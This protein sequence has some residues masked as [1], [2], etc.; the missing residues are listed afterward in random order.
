[1]THYA[2]HS[3]SI[4]DDADS[5]AS[6]VG[7]LT[8]VGAPI[9]NEVLKDQ[10]G[11]RVYPEQITIASQKP[12]MTF[13]T[14][15]LPKVIDGLGLIGRLLQDGSGK[16]GIALYQ[17][18]Y[19]NG[20]LASGSV[21]RR[22][23]F[24]R[25]HARI[26]RIS[27][28]HRQDAQAEC[29]AVALWDATNDPVMIEG[30]QALPTLPSS[31][32]RWTIGSL[33]V[34]SEVIGCKIQVDIDFGIQVDPFSCD[35]SVWDDHFHI[36]QIAPMIT[37]TSLDP[38]NFSDSAVI[39]EGLIGTQANSRLVLRKRTASQASFVADATAEHISIN[40]AG[41]IMAT[42][43]HNASGNQ[44]AQS[45]FRIETAWDGTNAPFVFDTTYA[46]A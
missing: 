17:A 7:S 40:F 4:Q 32:G 5:D 14:F 38:E 30:S 31:P 35:S 28:S 26:N 16:P 22:L 39:L 21:H 24:P 27:V 44:K 33:T 12:R 11:G 10:T 37:I 19:G 46:I 13:N 3:I 36:N 34:G 9:E 6:I 23:R 25:S 29:E 1:M 8:Q 20:S 43:A 18:K 42:D 41:V 2:N 15:D 45:T